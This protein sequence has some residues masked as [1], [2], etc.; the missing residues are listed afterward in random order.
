MYKQIIESYNQS[1]NPVEQVKKFE[2]L[3][4]EWTVDGGELT[5]TLKLRRKIIAEK[6]NQQIARI[7]SSL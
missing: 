3:P 4:N 5:P 2:L 1:F 7:Y 6:Y